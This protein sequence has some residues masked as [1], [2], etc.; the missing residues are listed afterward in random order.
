M[1]LKQGNKTI[2]TLQTINENNDYLLLWTWTWQS[3][4]FKN[5]ARY[6]ETT[7]F[8]GFSF[9]LDGSYNR[10]GMACIY[11]LLASGEDEIYQC[12]YNLTFDERDIDPSMPYTIELF[13]DMNVMIA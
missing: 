7:S 11:W 3:Q 1:S 6:F 5:A 2:L 9:G 13:G 4:V 12:H 10:S 8:L